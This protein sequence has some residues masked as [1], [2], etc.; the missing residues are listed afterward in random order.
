[1]D[2]NS[3]LLKGSYYT[4]YLNYFLK[5]FLLDSALNPAKWRYIF[6]YIW[7]SSL[8]SSHSFS[9]GVTLGLNLSISYLITALTFHLP[10]I[11]NYL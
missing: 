10:Y 8:F 6:V 4:I 9:V 1:M 5:I 7:T 11:I 3:C 2:P